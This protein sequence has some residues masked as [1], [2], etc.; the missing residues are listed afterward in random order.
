MYIYNVVQ[1][2]H[3]LV[4]TLPSQIIHNI[5]K[6]TKQNITQNYNDKYDYH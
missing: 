3:P 5:T 1:Y 6:V 2:K 4:V